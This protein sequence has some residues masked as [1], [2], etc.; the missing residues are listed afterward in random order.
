MKRIFFVS[1]K[2]WDKLK[3]KLQLLFKATYL[4]EEISVKIATK[5]MDR[6][7][8]QIETVLETLDK[9]GHGSVYK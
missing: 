8:G 3:Y 1:S 6:N 7:D 4:L 2:Y 9:K 5:K